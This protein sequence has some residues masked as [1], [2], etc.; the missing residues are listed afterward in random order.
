MGNLSLSQ[1][2]VIVVLSILL[3]GDI[4][5]IKKKLSHI[6]T[7]LDLSKISTIKKKNRKKGS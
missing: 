7:R 1:L 3:F 6:L 5:K 4:S 2:I